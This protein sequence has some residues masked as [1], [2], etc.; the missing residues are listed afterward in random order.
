M[1]CVLIVKIVGVVLDFTDIDHGKVGHEVFPQHEKSAIVLDF[2]TQ[3]FLVD[4]FEFL[5]KL[6][7]QL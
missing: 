5:P 7:I 3:F 2:M 1:V 4:R 6:Q